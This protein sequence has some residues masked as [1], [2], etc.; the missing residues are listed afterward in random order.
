MWFCSGEGGQSI[1]PFYT[2]SNK[3]WG[4]WGGGGVL[5]L[6]CLCVWA[7]FI[8]HDLVWFCLGEGGQ[9]IVSFYTLVP[10]DGG[11]AGVLGLLFVYV[12]MPVCLSHLHTLWL[13]WFCSGE[14]G[15][16]SIVSFYTPVTTMGWVGGGGG[17][18]L[19]FPC[20]CV[21]LP[22]CLS[23]V[24]KI[25]SKLLSPRCLLNCSSFCNQTCSGGVLSW[26]AVSCG[27]E[28]GCYHQGQGHSE[29]LFNQNMA[30][31][32]TS[33]EWMIFWFFF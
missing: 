28:L 1:L 12:C 25:S 7:I 11:G 24:Q 14:G 21:C 20:P 13:V 18:V 10:R 15:G 29:G 3:G 30:V 2:P 5:E 32:D 17:G 6:L 22:M 4:C 16:Q 9:S 26:A 31:S 19:A 8:C 27:K 23:F 33:P